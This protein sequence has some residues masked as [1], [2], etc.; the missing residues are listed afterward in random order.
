VVLAGHE[1]E[2]PSA[3]R[4][5]P[6]LVRYLGRPVVMGLRPAAFAVAPEPRPG[7]LLIVPLGV[8]SLGDEKHVLF[9]LPVKDPDERDAQDVPVAVDE[10]A[11]AALWTAKVGQRADLAIGRP[12]SLAVDF[13]SAYFFDPATG[14]AIPAIPADDHAV[15]AG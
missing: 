9:R 1:F 5:R 15:L 3:L 13:G 11:A 4:R 7:T 2:M 10:A 8:E 12:V 14:E 6:E